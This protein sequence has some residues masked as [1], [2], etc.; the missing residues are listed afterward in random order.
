VLALLK[1]F[2]CKTTMTIKC[3]KAIVS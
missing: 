3:R 1:F 2:N